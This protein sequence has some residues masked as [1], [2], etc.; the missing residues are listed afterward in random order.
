[1]PKTKTV[2]PSPFGTKTIVSKG[3]EFDP[4]QRLHTGDASAP[5]LEKILAR[6][7]EGRFRIEKEL[8]KGGMG[9]VYRAYD[10]KL[11]RVVAIKTILPEKK[12]RQHLLQR[13]RLEAVIA[14]TLRHPNIIQVYEVVENDSF[15]M[16]IMEYVE[17]TGLDKLMVKDGLPQK[18]LID[19]FVVICRAVG[20]AHNHG[21]LHRDIKPSNIMITK[22]SQPKIMDFGIAKRMGDETPYDPE[23]P[24][25][26]EGMLMGSPAFMSPE[27]ARGEH[28]NLDIRSDVYSLGASIYQGL[29][30]KK[31]FK[32][33][34][35]VEV[36]YHVINQ[37]LSPPSTWVKGIPSDLEGICIKAMDKDPETRYANANELADELVRYRD[38]LPVIAKRYGLKE[39]V[40]RSVRR[41]KRAFSLAVIALLTLFA[42]IAYTMS[43]LHRVSKDSL[44]HELQEK[45]KGIATTSTLLID[46]QVVEMIR[47]PMDKSKPECKDL[48]K[49]LKKIKKSNDR[50]AYV[51]IMRKSA[52]KKGYFEFVVEDGIYD[53]FEELDKNK[54]GSIDPDEESVEIGEIYEE[55]LGFPELKRGFEE[56]T[57]DKNIQLEDQ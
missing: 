25:T 3:I 53:T 39:R 27:Q 54:N 2:S 9:A 10:L 49:V 52:K 18:E 14:A 13:F 51:W 41:E 16:I 55:S 12:I 50:I 8:G 35:A 7:L 17:G 6:V 48:A 37:E 26:V 4:D 47:D 22:D 44:I 31:P 11:Q 24:L 32:G 29:T 33:K 45:V 21:V 42:G 46:P 40:F 1:M 43:I 15:P 19:F 28:Q 34:S 38:G 23:S 5:H 57:A 20:Y 56:P 36:V 30:G